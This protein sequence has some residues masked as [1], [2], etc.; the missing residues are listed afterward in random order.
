[1]QFL[2]R[3][4][5]NAARPVHVVSE[6]PVTLDRLHQMLEYARRRKLSGRGTRSSDDNWIGSMIEIKT[7]QQTFTAHINNPFYAAGTTVTI[8]RSVSWTFMPSHLGVYL[9]DGLVELRASRAGRGPRELMPLATEAADL[10]EIKRCFDHWYDVFGLPESLQYPAQAPKR[11]QASGDAISDI[12]AYLMDGSVQA[13]NDLFEDGGPAVW[14]DWGEEDDNIVRMTAKVLM[15]DDLTARF[16]NVTCDLLINFRGS[17]CRICYPQKGVADRDTTIIGLN[18]M[19]KPY[20]EL[21]L[22]N[23]SLG[24]DTLALMALSTDNW[25][26]LEQ[27]FP[28][29]CA[30]Q[31]AVIGERA[32]IFGKGGGTAR[33]G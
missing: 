9:I 31:F 25:L 30:R 18:M 20:Y 21:R 27:K 1:M 23:A 15:L 22:C 29:A 32:V 28:E 4:I 13:F 7:E 14:V 16:D 24:S 33:N 6:P 10:A 8:Y 19:L 5:E 3:M 11:L 2:K 26:H 12:Q 17:S